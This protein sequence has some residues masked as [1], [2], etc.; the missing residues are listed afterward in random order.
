MSNYPTNWQDNT[1]LLLQSPPN[2]DTLSSD[3]F[4]LAFVC[5][6]KLYHVGSNGAIEGKSPQSECTV[7]S[8]NPYEF[9]SKVWFET[10]LDTGSIDADANSNFKAPE[11]SHWGLGIECRWD[12]DHP[13]GW[14][15]STPHGTTCKG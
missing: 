1:L 7:K 14:Q 6:V 13:L 4:A 12:D 9:G 3:L 2:L 8:T 5:A 15:S 10:T 11:E